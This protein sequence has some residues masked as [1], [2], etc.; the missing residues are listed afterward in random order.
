MKLGHAYVVNQTNATLNLFEECT[1]EI[2]IQ[3]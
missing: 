3:T 2:G 1:L